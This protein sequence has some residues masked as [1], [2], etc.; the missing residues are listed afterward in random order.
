[1]AEDPRRSWG[2][3]RTPEEIFR[4]KLELE[5]TSRHS[6]DEKTDREA[7]EF[8]FHLATAWDALAY[9]RYEPGSHA[10]VMAASN[11]S[12]A[13]SATDGPG[14]MIKL[15]P[16]QNR[17]IDALAEV[18]H[19][20]RERGQAEVDIPEKLRSY[21]W[22]MSAEYQERLKAAAAKA[23][24]DKSESPRQGSPIEHHRPAPTAPLPETTDSYPVAERDDFYSAFWGRLVEQSS[25]APQGE[26]P[27]FWPSRLLTEFDSLLSTDR[28][29]IKDKA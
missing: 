10:E 12:T 15:N 20:P 18:A 11:L 22:H 28:E 14:P 19:L 4:S 17:I 7:R 9:E 2:G 6:D 8:F 25:I 1:M 21:K 24:G 27:A 13:A 29:Y 26:D 5:W 3:I 16:V 23:R